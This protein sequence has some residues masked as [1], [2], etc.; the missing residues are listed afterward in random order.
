MASPD[1]AAK[2]RDRIATIRA[3]MLTPNL[4]TN[5]ALKT[6]LSE[7]HTSFVGRKDLN[8]EW[9]GRVDSRTT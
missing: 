4:D 5:T 8:T 3:A 2:V 6:E 1:I 9:M 7:V